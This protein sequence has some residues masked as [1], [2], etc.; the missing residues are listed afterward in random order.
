MVLTSVSLPLHPT[1]NPIMHKLFV[2]PFIAVAILGIFGPAF[3]AERPSPLRWQKQM[4]AFAEKDSRSRYAKEGIVFVGSSS[5]RGWN[6]NKWFPDLPVL[7]RGFGGSHIADSTHF[8]ELLVL[9][10]KPR[11]VV[12]YA[13]DNDIAKGL[14]TDQVV[15]DYQGFVSKLYESLPDTRIV[16]VAIKPSLARWKLYPQMKEANDRIAAI[17]AADGRQTFLDIATKMTATENGQP[18]SDIFKKDGLHLNEAGYEIWTA[19]LM[20]H[21]K[22]P[23]TVG[24]R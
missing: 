6:L 4:D 17:A 19:L 23:E 11:C 15:A 16:F 2:H 12:L 18:R 20:P 3:A 5:I 7:N 8:L 22:Q 24:S 1:T 10:H 9:K 14:S 21:L 13:G